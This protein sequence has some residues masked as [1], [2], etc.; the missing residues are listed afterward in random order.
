MLTNAWACSDGCA[1]GCADLL[2]RLLLIVRAAGLLVLEK[3]LLVARPCATL[4]DVAGGGGVVSPLAHEQCHQPERRASSGL[5]VN[6]LPPP[7]YG[8]RSANNVR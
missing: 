1:D 4:G 8:G 2:G 3:C 7:G 5:M 6:Q